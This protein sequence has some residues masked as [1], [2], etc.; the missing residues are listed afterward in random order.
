MHQRL[1]NCRPS[2][3]SLFDCDGIVL[4]P[5]I[6]TNQR[7]KRRS[8]EKRAKNASEKPTKAD[9]KA[10]SS[11]P[12]RKVL[13]KAHD[14]SEGEG[15][16]KSVPPRIRRV[17]LKLNTP[18]NTT[19]HSL[20]HDGTAKIRSSI[21]PPPPL[22]EAELETAKKAVRKF[23][24]ELDSGVPRKSNSQESINELLD[25]HGSL[26]QEQVEISSGEE[27]QSE[28]GNHAE[29]TN[30]EVLGSDEEADELGNSTEESQ[31]TEGEVSCC[32][33]TSL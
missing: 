32:L 4:P 29:K 15:T 31:G 21:T 12:H 18:N 9:K 6:M 28:L 26:Y 24:G 19:N 27:S 17:N 22:E 20:D 14:E 13:Q 2:P 5:P 8:A 7:K 16:S 23:L 30:V 10:S 1:P 25:N 3:T 33:T 11:T